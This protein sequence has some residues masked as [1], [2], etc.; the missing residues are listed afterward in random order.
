MHEHDS[1]GSR[2]CL[3]AGSF[4]ER[5][6]GPGDERY[7]EARALFN[8]MIDKRPAVIARC[9]T[10]A[11]VA[12]VIRFAR[13]HDLPPRPRRWPQLGRPRQ[14]RRRRRH[15][16]LSD[17][18][19]LGRPRHSHGAG[20]RRLRGAEVDAATQPHA[21]AVPT[22]IISSTG[23]AGL[24]LGGGHGYL[25]RRHGLTIDNLLSAKMVLADGTQVTASADENPELF[26]AIRG[27]GG[28]FGVVTEFTFQAHPLETIVGGPTFW[29]IEDT[30]ALLA[31]YREWLPSAPRNV[32]GFFNW[33][34]I[35]PGEP[36]PR[37]STCASSA[38]SCGASTHPTRR[39]SRR[40]RRSWRPPSR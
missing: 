5:L 19:G 14:Q 34:T 29:A 11:D 6:V 32:S 37:R 28:N 30:D 1:L 8:A 35:P 36:F 24:T 13:E 3:R 23:V 20:R 26:W 27:G 2:G 12:A 18:I 40:W 25:T 7:D 33:H 4:G 22:G 10:A 16:S 15:R 9:E 38:G 31:L 17:E 39:R 21:L